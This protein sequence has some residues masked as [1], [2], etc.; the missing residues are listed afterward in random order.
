MR[1]YVVG[2]KTLNLICIGFFIFLVVCGFL[3]SL[4]VIDQTQ[5]VPLD[6]RLTLAAVPLA[7][8]FAPLAVLAVCTSILRL[9]TTSGQ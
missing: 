7:L 6:V 4:V 2:M 9:R 5:N 8:M 3:A 1:A